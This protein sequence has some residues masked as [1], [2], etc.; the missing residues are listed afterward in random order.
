MI[1]S[2][3]LRKHFSQEISQNYVELEGHYELLICSLSD[4]NLQ[5]AIEIIK[6]EKEP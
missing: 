4:M 6:S 3:E 2:F 1:K 5:K